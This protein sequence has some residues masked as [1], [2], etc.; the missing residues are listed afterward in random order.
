MEKVKRN[1]KPFNGEKYSVWKFRIRTLLSE[2]NLLS[3]ID[4]EIPGTRS[5]EWEKNNKAAKSIIVEYLADSYLNY[6]NENGTAQ[7]VFKHFDAIYERKSVATQLALRKQL[8]GLKLK[9]DIPLIKHFST[10][11]DLLTEL[12]AAGA[13]LEE[14]DKVAHLLL[15]VKITMLP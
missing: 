2:L 1:I 9:A 6:I 5:A 10:F 3:V 14:T 11:D 15:A 12:S 13:K 7:A 8:L 4:E